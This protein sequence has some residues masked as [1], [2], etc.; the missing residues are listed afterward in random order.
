MH[1]AYSVIFFTTASGAG[2][3]LLAWLAGGVLFGDLASTAAEGGF[4]PTAF[5]AALVLIA[6][7]L[8]SS[9]AHLGR[10]ERAWRAFSQW[11][12]SWLSREG[13]VAVASFAPALG[14]AAVWIWG[15]P[16]GPL[17]RALATA[18][19]VTAIATVFCTAMIYRSLTPVHQWCNGFVVP[20]Y[21]SLGVLTGGVVFQA[22]AVGFGVD[23]PNLGTLVAIAALAGFMVRR[24]YW[25]FIDSEPGAST[26]ESATG[27]G[28]LGR[29]EHFEGPHTSANYLLKEMGY[30]VARK[31]AK[32]LRGI[33][34]AALFMAPG[35]LSI[36]AQTLDGAAALAAAVIAVASAAAGVI[37]ERWLFFA[38]AKHAVTLYYGARSV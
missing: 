24:R 32:R 19:V 10:P 25:A 21:L 2:Y 27:L 1:P 7:G 37:A 16:Q 15:E 5:A 31:H 6:A 4:A 11:R 20:S 8:L 12:S 30:R 29:V 36:L 14:F 35:V 34:Y 17:I 13:V 9:T 38:E 28:H 26:P 23:A 18:S 3:G 33:V 22:L